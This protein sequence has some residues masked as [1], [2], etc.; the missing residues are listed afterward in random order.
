MSSRPPPWSP[1][2]CWPRRQ[3][4]PEG[5]RARPAATATEMK[6]TRSAPS[7][8]R[9]VMVF[10]IHSM[11]DTRQRLLDA[12]RQCVRS[13]GLA[14]TTS[15]DITGAADA[16]LAAITYHFGS[17]DELVAEAL[18]AGLRE[19]LDPALIALTESDDPATGMLTALQ[20]LITT[21]DQHRDGGAGPPRGPGRGA[22]A[23]AAARWVLVL[24]SELRRL[25]TEQ[26][27]QMQHARPAPQLDRSPADGR[28]PGG[29][30]QWCRS[31]NCGLLTPTAPPSMRWPASSPDC[32]W[33]FPSLSTR[34]WPA[35]V[36]RGLAAG[37]RRGG[38]GPVWGG[39]LRRPS[40][41][42]P[43]GAGGAWCCASSGCGA[44]T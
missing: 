18:L 7:A 2:C 24:W 6:A 3:S 14:R 36:G 20:T 39:V 12:T 43:R 19:W 34:S 17:K 15:R 25:L 4:V 23:S 38:Q 40:S 32:C 28:T 22:P 1:G 41:R 35:W 26:L 10:I 16:N 8:R 21:F 30:G 31:P 42:M 13:R 33:P 5:S 27:A 29:R 9:A 11:I 37:N 44:R